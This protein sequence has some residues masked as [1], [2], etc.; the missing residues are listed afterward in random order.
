MKSI[1]QILPGTLCADI[2]PSQMSAIELGI[3]LGQK[4]QADFP[5]VG[6]LYK[7]GFTLSM[8]ISKFSLTS[9]L[10]VN[11]KVAETAVYR[12]LRGYDGHIKSL[13]LKS[14]TGL[15]SGEELNLHGKE[16]NRISGLKVAQ[17]LMEQKKGIFSFTDKQKKDAIRKSVF[18]CGNIPYSQ[19]ELDF[20]EQLAN[21]PQYQ[22]GKLVKVFEIAFEVNIKFH[23]GKEVRKPRSISKIRLRKKSSTP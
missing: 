20:I 9:Y 11:F 13:D 4:I 14:Y 15:L 23:N 18:A 22:K 7:E 8:L 6:N 1:E 5:E 16:H 2:S 17:E 3:S 21:D 12:A 10:G 19:E